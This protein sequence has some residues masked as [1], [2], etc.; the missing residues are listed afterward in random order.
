M[1]YTLW[2]WTPMG[3]L[4]TN[5]FH[6]SDFI[7][8]TVKKCRKLATIFGTSLCM[9]HWHM[10]QHA[11]HH[12]SHRQKVSLACTQICHLCVGPLLFGNWTHSDSRVLHCRISCSYFFLMETDS[13]P[14]NYCGY[15]LYI[16][17]YILIWTTACSSFTLLYPILKTN[18]VTNPSSG[19][20]HGHMEHT[21][22]HL[23]KGE[24]KV[25]LFLKF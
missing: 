11:H 22:G 17:K 21:A 9:T 15:H 10:H 6:H 18:K 3:K 7:P 1:L 2:N 4:A 24:Y 14:L 23:T 8:G 19:D 13:R 5:S 16:F 25:E 20:Y 12:H